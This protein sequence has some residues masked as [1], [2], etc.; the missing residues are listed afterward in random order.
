MAL[1]ML[2]EAVVS[3]AI[4]AILRLAQKPETFI[5]LIGFAVS[6]IAGFSYEALLRSYIG[7]MKQRKHFTEIVSRY[8]M[9][10]VLVQIFAAAYFLIRMYQALYEPAMPSYFLVDVAMMAIF[11]LVIAAG[12]NNLIIIKAFADEGR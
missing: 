9:V 8:F 12:A 6:L 11:A 7:R 3:T 5:L 10:V 4:S 2:P 1:E